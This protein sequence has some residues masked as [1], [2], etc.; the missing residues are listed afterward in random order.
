MKEQ[1]VSDQGLL[2]AFLRSQ[3]WASQL[4]PSDFEHVLATSTLRRL[5]K[6]EGLVSSGEPARS[7]VGVIK[8]FVVQSATHLDGTATFL[9]AATGGSWFGEGTLLKRGRWMYDA[10][11]LRETVAAYVPVETFERLR[12][13]SMPFNHYLQDCM[14]D[15]LAHF[16]GLAVSARHSGALARVARTL[17]SLVETSAQPHARLF[18]RVTQSELAMLAGTSR[19]RANLALTELREQGIIQTRHSGIEI[20]LVDSLLKVANE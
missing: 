9:S 4:A 7:W 12:E 14:N 1:R 17:A 3:A 13:T 2:S 6:G 19:Q 11:A 8:G 10:I 16:I 5:G 20:S 15:R 18:I